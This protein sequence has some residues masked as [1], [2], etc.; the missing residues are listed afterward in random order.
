MAT[1]GVCGELLG[2]LASSW[3]CVGVARR[4]QSKLVG[5]SMNK[6]S[7]DVSACFWYTMSHATHLQFYQSIFARLEALEAKADRILTELEALRQVQ[8]GNA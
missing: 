2:N 5:V 4:A 7:H 8:S 3:S 6:G 1:C